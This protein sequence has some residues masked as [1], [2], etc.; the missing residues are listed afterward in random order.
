MVCPPVVRVKRSARFGLDN[1]FRTLHITGQRRRISQ[2]VNG[3][4]L[5]LNLRHE[6]GQLRVAGAVAL[7]RNQEYDPAAARH[8]LQ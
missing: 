5:P 4:V 8:I 6:F 7:F 3:Y 2:P 1:C